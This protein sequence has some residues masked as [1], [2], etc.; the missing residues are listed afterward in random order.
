[1]GMHLGKHPRFACVIGPFQTATQTVGQTEVS[2][3]FTGETGIGE[4]ALN[5]ACSALEI[6]NRLCGDYPY[7][8][9]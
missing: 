1:M 4:Q 8:S 2:V 3:F 9:Y 6:Y 5:Y 7:K